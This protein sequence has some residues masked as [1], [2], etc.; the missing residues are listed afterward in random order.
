MAGWGGDQCKPVSYL[1]RGRKGANHQREEDENRSLVHTVCCVGKVVED[2]AN[3]Y[4]KNGIRK[5]GRDCG[6]IVVAETEKP[7]LEADID[8]TADRDSVS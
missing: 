2:A 8:L 7:S 5:N 1:K 3:H 4:G 6:N